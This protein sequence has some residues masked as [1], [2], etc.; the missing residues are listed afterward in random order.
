MYPE[1]REAKHEI[2]QGF[3]TLKIFTQAFENFSKRKYVGLGYIHFK[4]NGN[5]PQNVV[6]MIYYTRICISR[7]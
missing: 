3:M 7:P 2:C 6:Y 1:K 5:E 4:Q